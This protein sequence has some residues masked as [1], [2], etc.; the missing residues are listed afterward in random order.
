MSWKKLIVMASNTLCSSAYFGVPVCMTRKL[1]RQRQHRTMCDARPRKLFK[2]FCMHVVFRT[3]VYIKQHQK[4]HL[5][6]LEPLS[7]SCTKRSGEFAT[8]VFMLPCLLSRRLS[9]TWDGLGP[10]EKTSAFFVSLRGNITCH[11]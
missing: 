10:V 1:N 4:I 7:P 3:C 5:E 8:Y 9:I 11:L 6:R 2:R